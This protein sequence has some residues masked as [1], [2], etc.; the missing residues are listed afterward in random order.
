MIPLADAG[1]RPAGRWC[2]PT[3]LILFLAFALLIPSFALARG[4]S[5]TEQNGVRW[6]VTP[7][8]QKFFSLGVNNVH[9]GT[10]GD[11]EKGEQAYYWQRF[12]PSLEAWGTDTQQRLTEWGFNTCGGWSDPSSVVSLPIIPEIDLGRN[13]KLH[14][15]DIFD[16]SMQ[17]SA[18]E[19]AREIM[20]KYKDNLRVLGFFTDNEVGWWN[21]PL[22]L[23]HLDKGWAFSSKRVLWQLLYDHYEGK[24]EKL[25]KDFVPAQGFDSFEKLKNDGAAL[26]LRP[27]GQGIKVV[28]EFTYQIARR[29]YELAFH[30]MRKADPK[31]LVVGDR[32]PLYYNQ[33]AV[34]AQKGLVDVL[35]TN[36]NVDCEDGWVAPYY[37]EGLRELSNSPV[38][39]SEYFFAAEENRSGNANNGHLMHVKTQEERARGAAAAM[40]NFAS[41]PNV[42]GVH[43]FQYSDEPTGGR[44]D[45]EDFNMGLVDIHN[46]PYKR[47][48]AAF[49]ALNPR[50]PNIHAA[51]RW[52]PKQSGDVTSVILRTP[53]PKN[54]ADGSLMDWPN[55]A[56]TRLTG[57]VTPKPHVPFGDV[58]LTWGPEGLYF[59]NIAGNYVDLSLLDYQ[60]EFPL[61][62]T[63]Q[64]GITVDAGA[65]PKSF[66][67]HLAPRPHRI[68]PGRYE[69]VP[70]LWR[71]ENGQ[72]VERITEKGLVQALDKPLPHIQVEG[73]I[74]AGLLGVEALKPGQDVKVSIEV[75]NF[76]RELTMALGAKTF[77][78]GRA[79]DNAG[80]AQ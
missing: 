49:A 74:S 32:L 26:K 8:G 40:G 76:Y 46:Q 12:Y 41:F 80:A 66:G 29:Y 72:P 24:W 67:V 33:D 54:L 19:I 17:D 79:T 50:I 11:K 61:S 2:S 75:T 21:A 52:M 9:G 62:E 68:W 47:L 14:W 58:H 69:L 4:W 35:S 15:Y 59:F 6:L 5:V 57:F 55:K 44:S 22:F 30:A 42:A 45:G 48:T 43:W 77:A 60:G 28:D 65:G 3:L 20:A 71:Y 56:G 23:W 31:A 27:G 7:E 73:L 34:L 39:I 78:L 16:P 18:D 53:E 63:Y 51:S 25:L 38:L 13:S 10:N 36:Y 37:F 64:I 1:Q 70:Q